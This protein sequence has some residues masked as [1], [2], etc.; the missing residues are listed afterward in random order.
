MNIL[1]AS[2]RLPVSYGAFSSIQLLTIIE[3]ELEK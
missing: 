1:Y 3:K 2:M